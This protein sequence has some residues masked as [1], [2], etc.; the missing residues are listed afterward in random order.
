MWNLIRVIVREMIYLQRKIRR[1]LEDKFQRRKRTHRFDSRTRPI[2][3]PT[4][5]NRHP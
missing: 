1:F 4:A 2:C 5:T 3:A